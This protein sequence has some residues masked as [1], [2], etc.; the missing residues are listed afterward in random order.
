MAKRPFLVTASPIR[1]RCPQ[2]KDAQP[3]T[4]MNRSIEML[5]KRDCPTCIWKCFLGTARPGNNQGPRAP[6]QPIDQGLIDLNTFNLVQQ[7]FIGLPGNE[8]MP[9]HDPLVRNNEWSC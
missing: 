8:S 9:N 7:H 3:L 5:L 6:N 1:S 2:T 4:G